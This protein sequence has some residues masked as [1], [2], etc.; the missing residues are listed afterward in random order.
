MSSHFAQTWLP[1]VSLVVLGRIDID[2]RVNT[3]TTL[4]RCSEERLLFVLDRLGCQQHVFSAF[5]G[6][7][8]AAGTWVCDRVDGLVRRFEEVLHDLV[9]LFQERV[10]L[11]HDPVRIRFSLL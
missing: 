3:A 8:S 10:Q 9:V 5:S 2:R 4:E 6:I 7:F 11:R 1:E